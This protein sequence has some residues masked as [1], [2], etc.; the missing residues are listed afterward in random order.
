MKLE[1]TK[2]ELDLYGEIMQL[3]KPTFLEAKSYRDDLSKL[4]AGADSIETVKSFLEKMGL[5]K[6]KFDTLEFEHVT[7]ILE[8]LLGS[9][10]N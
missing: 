5:S 6:D 1:R 10:K 8:T 9:K 4:D 7:L 2:I 3:R